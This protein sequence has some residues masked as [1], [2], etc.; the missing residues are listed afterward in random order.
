M[1]TE[2]RKNEP[3]RM[4]TPSGHSYFAVIPHLNGLVTE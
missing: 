3:R 1:I 2:K 4:M